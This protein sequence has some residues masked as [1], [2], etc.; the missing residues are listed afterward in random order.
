MHMGLREGRLLSD[1]D[2]DSAIVVVLINQRMAQSL[3]PNES[4]I[5]KRIH[6]GPDNASKPWMTIVGVVDDVRNSW[7]SDQP[8]RTIYSAYRQAPQP[9]TTVAVRTSG[10]PESV[11]DT[12]SQRV[13]A[14]DPELPIYHVQPSAPG[15]H[16]IL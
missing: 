5:G 3:W 13:A 9:Y 6:W 7:I 1:D 11:N 2:N 10:T 4:W 15:I 12:G 16:Y 14:L 8:E